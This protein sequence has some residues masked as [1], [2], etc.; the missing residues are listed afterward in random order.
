MADQKIYLLTSPVQSGKTTSLIRWSENR[1]DV[2]GVL[3]PVEHNKRFFL[4]VHT[5][6]RFAMEATLEETETLAVGRFIF[7]R[8][9]FEKAIGIIRE[10][11]HEEGWLI[12]DEI[13]PLELRGEGFCEILK[14]VLAAGNK[15]QKI[16]LVVR[17]GMADKVGKFF[18]LN[19]YILVNKISEFN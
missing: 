5:R 15:K 16:V 19:D 10:A 8:A 7:S 11:I 17:E 13:G 2:F 4:N 9:N 18:L 1:D 6:E 14:E 3:T 12:I